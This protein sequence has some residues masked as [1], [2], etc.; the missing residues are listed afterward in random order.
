[1]ERR[2]WDNGLGRPFYRPVGMMLF[3][4]LTSARAERERE[5]TQGEGWGREGKGGALVPSGI[6]SPGSEGVEGRR[7]GVGGEN[8]CRRRAGRRRRGVPEAQEHG[9]GQA[10]ERRRGGEPAARRQVPR[11]EGHAVHHRCVR[12][13][14]F[15]SLALS[16]SV[17]NCQWWRRYGCQRN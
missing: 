2:W 10:G 14:Q 6:V 13:C 17:S 3:S 9:R 15:S 12:C 5:N 7:V 16:L 11:L 8:A 4:L 1:V